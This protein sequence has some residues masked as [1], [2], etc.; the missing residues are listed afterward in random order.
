M[1]R[2]PLLIVASLLAAW[3]GAGRG[4][5]PPRLVRGEVAAAPWNVV[6]GGIAACDVLVDER[7]AVVRA[8]LV[9]DVPPYGL[10]LREDILSS[11]RFEPAREN[12]RPM[13]AHVLVLGLF[14][15]PML[16]MPAPE[17]PLYKTTKAPETLPWPTDVVVPPYPPNV[18]GSGKVIVET[19]VS[20]QGGVA[21]ARVLSP[22]GAFDAAA[23]EAIRGW[24]F[25]PAA[26]A[27][28]PLASRAFLVVSFVGTTPLAR[29]AAEET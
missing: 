8:E 17:R 19:D 4:L 15:P 18:I 3:A 12:G 1:G 23:L 28:R 27:G 24:T 29:A 6:S 10:Q 9:Q 11:W 20:E 2:A 26:L 5:E 14:L 25:R 22:P 7:G 21:S 13:G 16:Q